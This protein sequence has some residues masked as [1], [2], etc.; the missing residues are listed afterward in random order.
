MEGTAAERPAGLRALARHLAP[1]VK[2]FAARLNRHRTSLSA[3]GLAYFVAISIGPAAIAVG[4]IA[5][6]IIGP[7]NV[8]SALDE[9]ER[10]TPGLSSSLKPAAN[11]LTDLISQSSDASLTAA[12]IVG[13]IVAVYGASRTV[14]FLRISLNTAF[15]VP[16]RYAGIWERI[17]SALITLAGMVAAVAVMLVLTIVPMI[18]QALDLN[19][20]LFTGV[21]VVDWSIVA[22]LTWLACHWLIRRA[23]NHQSRIPWWSPGPIVAVGWMVTCTVGL[24]LYVR[25]SGS[26][27]AA[28]AIFGSAV[29]LLLWLYLC[30]M[31]LL[32]GAEVEAE[33]QSRLSLRTSGV[34]PRQAP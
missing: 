29:V 17:A 4:G 34:D 9:V 3:G 20:R 10:E 21:A 26:L 24:G 14:S 18:L 30:L 28:I 11:S 22:L 32:I 33:R 8:R 23:A 2:D 25:Y 7:E 5:G 27:G 1:Q 19:V 31:G 13:F 15:D 12:T 16:E 6:L